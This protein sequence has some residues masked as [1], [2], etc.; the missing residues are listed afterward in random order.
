MDFLFHA[1]SGLRYL[2]L[3]AGIIAITGV[4]LIALPTGLFAA[5]FSEGIERHRERN[6]RGE[7]GD[8]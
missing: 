1:H 2:V 4:M 5:S 3:L 7:D 8:A 6:S